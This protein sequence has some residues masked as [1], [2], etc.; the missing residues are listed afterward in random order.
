[1]TRIKFLALAVAAYLSLPLLHIASA[2]PPAASAT[3]TLIRAGHVLNVH[4]GAEPADQ[5]I[6]VV[7][8]KISAIAATSRH[9]SRQAIW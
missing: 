4:T 8:E 2:Q 9:R 5:T 6:V 3:R 7:G 1:M